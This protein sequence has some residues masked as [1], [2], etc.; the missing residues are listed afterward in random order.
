MSFVEWQ[1]ATVRR[2]RI[3]AGRSNGLRGTRP[4]RRG[5][6]RLLTFMAP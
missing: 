6:S 4:R 1:S 3:G 2:E 5:T